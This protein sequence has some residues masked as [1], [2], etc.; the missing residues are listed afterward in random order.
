MTTIV[1]RREGWP[2]GGTLPLLKA[3]RTPFMPTI[4]GG[5][6]AKRMLM[7]AES[8]AARLMLSQGSDAQSGWEAMLKKHSIDEESTKMPREHE[9]D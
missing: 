9:A 1:G 4:V 6:T 8:A 7:N 2:D 5:D 3:F